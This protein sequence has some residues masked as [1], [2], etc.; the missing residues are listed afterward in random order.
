MLVSH[1]RWTPPRQ[2]FYIKNLS[3]FLY[4]ALWT[5]IFFIKNLFVFVY[6]TRWTPALNFLLLIMSPCSFYYTRWMSYN[7]KRRVL[8]LNNHPITCWIY[9]GFV[10]SE[11]LKLTTTP[12]LLFLVT[13]IRLH[14][15]TKLLHIHNLCSWTLTSLITELE[16][17]TFIYTKSR[18]YI[19]SV[20]SRFITDQTVTRKE[21]VRTLI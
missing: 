3:M 11:V 7:Q 2:F 4:H 1:I 19:L 15:P 6:R 12:D 5:L 13:R 9:A 8:N 20:S 21:V 14:T 17:C 16:T 18:D 10:V